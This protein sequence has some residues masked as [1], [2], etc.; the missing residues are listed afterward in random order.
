MLKRACK[1]VASWLPGTDAWFDR[2]MEKSEQR[3]AE[4]ELRLAVGAAKAKEEGRKFKKKLDEEV[5][6]AI[7]EAKRKGR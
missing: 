1:W 6:A 7:E 2:V 3:Q 5:K 4:L